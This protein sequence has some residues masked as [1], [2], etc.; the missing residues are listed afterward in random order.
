MTA[1]G[2]NFGLFSGMNLVRF[3]EAI[4]IY[5]CIFAS[6][7]LKRAMFGSHHLMLD[8]GETNNKQRMDIQ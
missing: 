3:R 7:I 6:Y 4:Y 1:S 2:G 8:A 5:I